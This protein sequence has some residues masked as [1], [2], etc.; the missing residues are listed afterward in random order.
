[1]TWD[2]CPSDRRAGRGSV[3]RLA[4][5]CA[6]H[7]HRGDGGLP[8]AARRPGVV[9]E[10]T[11]RPATRRPAPASAPAPARELAPPL[12]TWFAGRGWRPFAF[13]RELWRA[14]AD[15]ESG[16]LHATTG[17]GKTHAAWLGALNR[18]IRVR[19]AARSSAGGRGRPCRQRPRHGPQGSVSP[20]CG[21]PRVL[22]LTPMRALATDTLKAL[23]EPLADEAVAAALRGRG[24]EPAVALRTGDTG[25]AERAR[26]RGACRPRW[27]P[28]PRACR[29]C[30]RAPMRRAPGASVRMVVVDEWHELLGNKRG[31][32]VQLALARLRRLVTRRWR[33]GACRPRSA[34]STMRWTCCVGTPAAPAR[35][36]RGHDR[37]DAHRRHAA[38]RRGRALS[39]GRPPGHDDAAAGGR[40]DRGSRTTLVFTNT[41]SQ[42]ELWYQALL[43]ARPD[44]AGLI[45][46]H[47]GSLDRDVRDWVEAGAEGR[48]LKA[49]VCTSSLDLGRRLPAGRAG[50]ADRLG[51]GRGAAAAARRPLAAMRRAGRR[52]SRW[53]RRTAS[54]CSRRAAARDA[55]R[56]AAIEARSRPTEPL[57]V[58]VQH[59]VTVA[60]GGGLRG[61]RAA[62][63]GAQR[64]APTAT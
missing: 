37:Q 57:D 60:L 22:W 1:M 40:R 29:C 16:L 3:V 36:V 7:D 30:C 13:Q 48:P 18:F 11:A 15:G 24:I 9:K 28:R 47:H 52:A 31:V 38:A 21:W 34:T 10:A 33:S 51:Q 44:W 5:R 25:R 6:R 49:V 14:I 64:R 63:R 32:Q 45:A 42:A 19:L 43:E 12:A 23:A 39:V 62:R 4:T 46:L 2:G 20:V 26:R 61:R 50:A 58:L 56:R 53:C 27:S 8:A 59:L 35:I 55:A 41:R 54:S 17:A